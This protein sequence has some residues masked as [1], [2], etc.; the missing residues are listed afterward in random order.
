MLTSNADVG[1]V[2]PRSA[3]KRSLAHSPATARDAPELLDGGLGGRCGT[4][5]ARPGERSFWGDRVQP[6]WRF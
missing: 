6:S 3:A 5:I 1:A 4:R 2:G